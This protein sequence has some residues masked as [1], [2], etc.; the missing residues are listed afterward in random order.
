MDIE[1]E[2]RVHYSIDTVRELDKQAPGMAWRWVMGS[3][4]LEEAPK[5]KEWEALMK[6]APPLVIPRAGHGAKNE[7]EKFALP[8]IS[9]T[10]IRDRVANGKVKELK[11]IVPG[12]VLEYI[13][14]KKLYLGK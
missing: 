6:L 11:S 12:G 8:G 1:K 3:D 2:T 13:F 5:W 10:W 4:T 14:E 7:Q 9:S